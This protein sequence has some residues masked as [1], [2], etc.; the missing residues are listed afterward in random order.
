MTMMDTRVGAPGADVPDDDLDFAVAVKLRLDRGEDV[1]DAD[2]DRAVAIKLRL[3][4]GKPAREPDI[5]L[6]DFPGD[7]PPSYTLPTLTDQAAADLAH[8]APAVAAPPPPGWK[9]PGSAEATPTMLGEAA[10][11]LQALR[12]PRTGILAPRDGSGQ[13]MAGSLASGI[14]RGSGALVGAGGGLLRAAGQGLQEL[15]LPGGPTVAGAGRAVEEVAR[16]QEGL[17]PADPARP[18]SGGVGEAIPGMAAALA[19]GP[20]GPAVFGAQGAGGA[21]SRTLEAT[22]SPQTALGAAGASGLVNALVAPAQIAAVRG[23]TPGLANVLA[24]RVNG[25]VGRYLAGAGADLSVG[26]IANVAQLAAEDTIDTVS[27][28]NPDA[29]QDFDRHAAVAAVVGATLS[30][31]GAHRAGMETARAGMA[32]AAPSADVQQARPS[33]SRWR[34]ARTCPTPRCSSGS[35][36]RPRRCSART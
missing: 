28:A 21:Y 13:S 15:G 30:G 7:I 8:A 14:V 33:P 6:P 3:G 27:G 26:A 22:G 23:V 19:A 20:A 16:T 1:P 4:G 34:K 29:F 36:A 2:L 35:R 9:P 10:D 24:A 12:D 11:V 32:P 18:F 25:A 5:G 17:Y 31:Y